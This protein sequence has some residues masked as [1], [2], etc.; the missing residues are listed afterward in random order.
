[1]PKFF[2]RFRRGG[3]GVAVGGVLA[4]LALAGVAVGASAAS[5]GVL[6]VY[7]CHWRQMNLM[8]GWQSE[9]GVYNTGNPAYC[10]TGEGMV[11]LSGSL[12]Q[13]TAGSNE[14]TVLPPQ[15]WPAHNLYL[16]VYTFQG[17]SGVLEIDTDG[18]VLAYNA[19]YQGDSKDFTSL[20]GI[21]YPAVGAV[22]E[23]PLTLLN[24]WQSAQ[25]EWGTGDPSYSLINGIVHLSG[26][27]DGSHITPG[28]GEQA[29]EFAVLP[30]EARPDYCS[31]IET[32]DYAGSPGTVEIDPQGVMRSFA[33][34][35]GVYQ[36]AASEYTSLAGLAY[37]VANWTSWQQLNLIDGWSQVPG[38]CASGDNGYPSFYI[39]ENVVYLTGTLG[40]VSPNGNGLFAVLPPS[41]RP[42]DTLYI[43]LSNEGD[44]HASLRISPDG[45]MYLFGPDPA[46]LTSLAGLSYYITS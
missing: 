28:L 7:S 45:S 9:E 26:S 2:N 33:E 5:A 42:Y 46:G 16:S 22:T 8:N 6:P 17:A 29:K 27:L 15:A 14:V 11:Y 18:A 3:R 13:P 38:K 10:V 31:P 20:A 39:K 37:P 35:G 1:M 23:K 4:S 19:Q 40:Q 34:G 25:S 30:Q 36:T 43:N 41:A 12:A 32:Y 21:S 44:P 24:G